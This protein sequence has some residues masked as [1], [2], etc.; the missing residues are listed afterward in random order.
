MIEKSKFLKTFGDKV[1][2]LRQ[3]LSLSQEDLAERAGYTSRS[4]ISK[5][6][7]GKTDVARNKVDDLAKALST[8]PAYLMGWEDLEQ[9]GKGI[10]LST[11]SNVIL[12]KTRPIPILGTICA[13]DG[14][15]CEENFE[16]YFY[17]DNKIKGDF[18]IKVKGD[19][20]IDEGIF[21]G[22]LVFLRKD[23]EF[24]A[25]AIYAVLI[26]DDNSCTLKK[27][28]IAGDKVILTPANKNYKP[29]TEDVYNVHIIGECAGV[30]HHIKKK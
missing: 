9:S 20:M 25:G 7:T 12:P 10:D 1:K 23:F 16:G 21:E 17:A 29:I 5:I 11:I 22:D 2:K 26:K 4:S 24:M 14:I 3:E 30:Y 8:T 19:S 18:A 27:V 13:G 28:Y 15:F 6:E